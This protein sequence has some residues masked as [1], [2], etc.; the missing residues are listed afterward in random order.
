LH[1]DIDLII[2][3]LTG[4]GAFN[5]NENKPLAQRVKERRVVWEYMEERDCSPES[6]DFVDQLMKFSSVARMSL[7]GALAHSWLKP[8]FCPSG[9]PSYF[10]HSEVPQTPLSDAPTSFAGSVMSAPASAP[11]PDE[12][13]GVSEE[14]QSLELENDSVSDSPA[15]ITLDEVGGP[16]DLTRS[17]DLKRAIEEREQSW[18]LVDEPGDPEQTP[19]ARPKLQLLDDER[20]AR[21]RPAVITDIQGQV[22]P[23][24]P[25]TKR[26]KRKLSSD[27]M[28]TPGGASSSGQETRVGGRLGPRK[29]SKASQYD[30]PTT[31][32]RGKFPNGMD[33]K[34]SLR[35]GRGKA[36]IVHDYAEDDS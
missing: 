8:R 25:P 35:S 20:T 21:P 13:M 3:R 24:A 2:G 28:M 29:A 33:R 9:L 5:E 27:E 36:P 10:P 1:G 12:M 11:T 31:A 34:A 7:T 6:K 16:S 14:F 32:T 18:D 15:Y 26:R 30:T 17:Q 19:L 23:P 4:Q 22:P